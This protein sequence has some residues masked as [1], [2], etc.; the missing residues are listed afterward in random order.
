M[1]NQFGKDKNIELEGPESRSIVTMKTYPVDYLNGNG[2]FFDNKYGS[3]Y[4]DVR[5]VIDD[6][7]S[8]ITDMDKTNYF[9]SNLFDYVKG[10]GSSHDNAASHNINEYF[11]VGNQPEP[12]VMEYNV[13]DKTKKSI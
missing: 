4:G 7:K 1:N 13:Y 8:N 2:F 9:V 11:K 6:R 12:L 5:Y 10:M 3:P